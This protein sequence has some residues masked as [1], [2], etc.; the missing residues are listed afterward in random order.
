MIPPSKVVRKDR[1]STARSMRMGLGS[2][3]H[4]AE[5]I[6]IKCLF[7]IIFSSTVCQVRGL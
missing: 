1:S 6:T 5:I 2:I 7:Q 4:W 3:K